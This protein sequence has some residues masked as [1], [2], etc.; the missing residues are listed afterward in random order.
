MSRVGAGMGM[1]RPGH[2][3]PW[4]TARIVATLHRHGIYW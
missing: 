4:S 2:I 3:R 1:H